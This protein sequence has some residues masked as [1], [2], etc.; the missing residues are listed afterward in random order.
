LAFQ[1][2]TVI[3]KIKDAVEA[4]EPLHL[5]PLAP[6]FP[7]VD[8]IVYYPNEVLT[9]IQITIRSEHPIAVS[10]LRHIQR[11]LKGG[12]WS[13]GLRPKR[14]RPWRFVFI[15]PPEMASTFTWQK[16]NGD[17]KLGAWAG[18]VEQYVLGLE[19]GVRNSTQQ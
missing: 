4:G 3:D 13:A 19:V 10:G 6:N 14:K 1:E 16:L 12:T 8:S 2:T 15:V 5:V 9:C 18:K 7:A 17:T 11:R